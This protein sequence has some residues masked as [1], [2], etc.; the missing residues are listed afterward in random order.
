MKEFNKILEGALTKVYN[1][2]INEWDVHVLA[3][4]FVY[5][6]TCKTLTGQTPFRLIYSVDAVMRMGYIVPSLCIVALI[7]MAD[8]KPW[9]RGSCS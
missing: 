7:G 6:M 3:V 5:R 9:K 1:S 8:E 2:Q 4:L